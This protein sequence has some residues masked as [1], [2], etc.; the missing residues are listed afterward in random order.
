MITS[1]KNPKVQWIRR[2]QSK[3]KER[4][5]EQAFV[6]EGVRL[7]EE[8]HSTNWDLKNIFYTDELSD[9]G[10]SL[11]QALQASHIEVDQVS[12]H[13]M[14]SMSD[15]QNPQGIA[16]VVG[17]K[18][19]PIPVQLDLVLILDQLRDPGNLGAVLRTSAAANVQVV[20]LTPSTVD[21]FSPKVLRA[22]MGAHFRQPIQT[23]SW[24]ELKELIGKW[25]LHTYLAAS[26]GENS[27][28]LADFR[29][30]LA[31]VIGGEAH[32]A[33]DTAYQIADTK[34]KIL[35]PGGGES[36]NAAVAAGI[37]LFE[38]ARQ[39]EIAS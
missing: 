36:L 19:L 23:A 10:K 9:R 17:M 2:L 30:S 31:M 20:Y 27:H 38:I 22:G 12:E 13:V 21:A 5:A 37:L 18:T 1:R 14:R 26:S 25:K 16:A 29:R 7:V 8:A 32:G 11:V 35:M 6:I 3:T 15:T 24:D 28:Y 4:L 33:S 39:R 34:I